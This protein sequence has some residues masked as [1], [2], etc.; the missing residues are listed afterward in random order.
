MMELSHEAVELRLWADND[1]ASYKRTGPALEL[2]AKKMLRDDYSAAK[3]SQF[4]ADV[5]KDAA[6]TYEAEFMTP[7]SWKTVFPR[8]VRLE[9]ADAMLADLWAEVELGNMPSVAS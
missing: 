4:L 2:L 7:G 6:K 5:L 1:S 8:W 9:A 3:A